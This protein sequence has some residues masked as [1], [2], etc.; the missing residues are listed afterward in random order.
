[1][2]SIYKRKN[3]RAIPNGAEISEFR[4]KPVAEWIG[5]DKRKHRAP[6]TEDGQKIVTDSA[7][8]YITY[9]DENGVRVVENSKAKLV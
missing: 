1:M 7:N 4:G 6:L 9:S 3:K 2:G 8:W 5:K